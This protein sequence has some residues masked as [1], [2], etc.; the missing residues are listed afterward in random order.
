MC[1]D[2]APPGVGAMWSGIS[3]V[4]G[5]GGSLGNAPHVLETQVLVVVR[6][7]IPRGYA[8]RAGAN[9]WFWARWS[10]EGPSRKADSPGPWSCV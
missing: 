3:L 8:A 4:P 10:S 2:T 7:D 6:S 1:E 5:S 9:S